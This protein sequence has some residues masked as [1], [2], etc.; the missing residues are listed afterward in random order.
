MYMGWIIVAVVLIVILVV[1]GMTTRSDV[2]P[3][4]NHMRRVKQKGAFHPEWIAPED[5]MQTVVEHY[6]QYIEFAQET[7]MSGWTKYYHG[8]SNYLSGDYLRLQTDNID[9]RLR[10]DDL[11]L[12]DILRANHE[13]RVR[14]FG[15]DGLSCLLLDFQTER[16]LATYHY[17]SKRRI[18]TQHLD[19]VICV[20]RMHFDQLNQRWKIADYIQELPSHYY[21]QALQGPIDTLDNALPP[22]LGR[23]D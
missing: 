13:V 11:R 22:I 2:V 3:W 9:A 19:D 18:H 7:L 10:K 12:I 16:R 20:Y 21:I 1:V 6:M 5:I 4:L 23:D 8:L 17:W 15:N 14:D